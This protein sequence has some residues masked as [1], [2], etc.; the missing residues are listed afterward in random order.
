MITAAIGRIFLSAYNERYSTDYDAK[1][2]FV[3]VYFPLFYGHGKYLMSAGNNPLE[4]PKISWGKM[5]TGEIPYENDQQRQHRLDRLMENAS[6]GGPS[7]D[8]AIGF[9]SSDPLSITAG[10]TT[11]INFGMGQEDALY[12]W[13]GASLGIGVKGGYSILFSN[14]Q[15][16][17]DIY[18]G[19]QYYRDIIDN[20]AM[21]RGNQV[22]TWNGQW[23]R[24]RYGREYNE[25][26]PLANMNITTID[27]KGIISVDT[28]SWTQVLIGIS[29]HFKNNMQLMGYIY[30]FG[31]TNTTLGFYPFLLNHIRRPVELYQKLFGLSEGIK[32]ETLWG[33][34][35]GL[36][37]CCQ[38]G[39]I[40][41]RAMEPKALKGTKDNSKLRCNFDNE[42][43]KLNFNTYKIWLMAL[44]NSKEMWDESLEFAKVLQDY[45]SNSGKRLNTAR[46]NKVDK[47]LTSRGKHTFIAAA[48]EMMDDE[49]IAESLS[50]IVQDVHMMPDN[51]VPYFI[52][53]IR[54]NKLALDKKQ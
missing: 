26:R 43:E 28:T 29:R 39:A 45:L 21:Q 20:T 13:F 46:N 10:Q 49:Q 42:K 47:L 5:L 22:N 27:N 25:K 6:N 7:T 51:N 2:F 31:Q 4:N 48:T 1:R 36:S 41:L 19:W 16:L 44:L 32:A 24:H 17:M 37:K 34:E 23:L 35:R 40:G 38:A 8:N 12:S 18:D 15:I 50:K 53:L 11:N 52:T 54:F 3:E 14:K 33:T 9:A 30:N